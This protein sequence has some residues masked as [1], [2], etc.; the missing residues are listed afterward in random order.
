MADGSGTPNIKLTPKQEAFVLA[1]LETGNATEAYR[2]AYDASGMAEATINVKACELLKNGKVAGRLQVLRERAAAKVV[3][4]RSWV[5][6]GLMRNAQA[7]AMKDDFTASNKAYELLGKTDE[8]P[9][10]VERSIVQ[11]DN[12]HHHTVDA[13]S[14]FDG[15]LEE[16]AGSGTE[17]DPPKPLQN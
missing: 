1:Y 10:F 13:V 4:T 14:A 3:L 2:R 9:L 7:A 15:F 8:V 17:G 5:L 6:E 16:A 11:S 12:R